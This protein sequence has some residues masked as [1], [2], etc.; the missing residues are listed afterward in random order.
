MIFISL[1]LVFFLMLSDPLLQALPG[2][3]NVA[4]EWL[5]VY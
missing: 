5:E 3:V 1:E 2:N 4:T